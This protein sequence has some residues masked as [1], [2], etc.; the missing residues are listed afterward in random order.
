MPHEPGQGLVQESSSIVGT[1]PMARHGCRRP[2]RIRGRVRWRPGHCPGPARLR[3][4]APGA[5]AGPLRLRVVALFQLPAGLC[6][7]VRVSNGTGLG[8]GAALVFWTLQGGAPTAGGSLA[9][10]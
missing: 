10:Q 8:S 2:A 7:L 5:A 1:G 3:A 9:T 6:D 4:L